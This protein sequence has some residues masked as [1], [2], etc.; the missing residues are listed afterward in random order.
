MTRKDIARGFVSRYQQVG[1]AAVKELA[2]LLIE[3]KKTTD[4]VLLI[5][6][7]RAEL[8]RVNSHISAVV[9]SATPLSDDFQKQI[10]GIIKKMTNAESV[11]IDNE[12]E[13]ELLGGFV[14]KAPELE[15]DAS[16]RGKL[17]QLKGV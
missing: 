17:A 5:E 7:V 2:A 8:A 1:D 15:Y 9:Q 4:V 3:N 12:L 11:S 16:V 14:I 6:E 10:M 13:P